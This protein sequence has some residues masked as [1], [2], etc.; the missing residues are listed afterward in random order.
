M[1]HTNEITPGDKPE[2]TK[3]DSIVEGIVEQLREDL[4]ANYS[5]ILRAAEETFRADENAG[6]PEAKISVAIS[7]D[8]MAE[9]PE[10]DIKLSWAARFAVE[11][12]VKIDRLQEKLPFSMAD[13]KFKKKA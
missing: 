11:N 6:N 9:E 10:V 7:F 2:L 5:A 13:A 1:S 12:T 8:P 4:H 3:E